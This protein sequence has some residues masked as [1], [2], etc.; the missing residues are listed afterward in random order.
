MGSCSRWWPRNHWQRTIG[1]YAKPES[2]FLLLT[3]CVD[4]DRNDRNVQP[5]GS[6][7]KSVVN[8]HISPF[9]R[10]AHVGYAH[11]DAT[12]IHP[13]RRRSGFL[14]F[15]NDQPGEYLNEH[16]SISQSTSSSA[17][18][19][20]LRSSVIDWY[21][22]NVGI[23]HS[24]HCEDIPD[25]TSS[26]NGLSTDAHLKVT[27]GVAEETR[28]PAQDIYT[29]TAKCWNNAG[30]LGLRLDVLTGRKKMNP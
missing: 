10:P 3:Y 9:E 4:E 19:G 23:F 21:G 17:C 7:L 25:A 11:F 24:I 14:F 20:L 6:R 8:S 2:N 5:V 27:R 1:F 12:C 13:R 18:A 26:R 30:M 22:R 16:R 29:C 28:S 15:K